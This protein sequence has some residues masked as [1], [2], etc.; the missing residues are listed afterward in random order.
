MNYSECLFGK[1]NFYHWSL[2]ETFANLYVHLLKRNSTKTILDHETYCFTITIDNVILKL[3]YCLKWKETAIYSLNSTGIV[4]ILFH[5]LLDLLKDFHPSSYSTVS[6]VGRNKT[7]KHMNGF[8]STVMKTRVFQEL[9]WYL[10]RNNFIYPDKVRFR[11]QE[12][13]IIYWKQRRISHLRK[14]HRTDSIVVCF[15]GTKKICRKLH[16]ASFPKVFNKIRKIARC[17]YSPNSAKK[18][19]HL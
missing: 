13:N 12:T 9:Y 4:K 18:S 3:K 5:F 8:L 17:N 15:G 7:R 10:V 1:S 11:V 19:T 14:G 2:L 6:H 16:L